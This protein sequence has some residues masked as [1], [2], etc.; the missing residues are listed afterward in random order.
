MIYLKILE[1]FTPGV[2]L[3]RVT[4]YKHDP[5]RR[6][7]RRVRGLNVMGPLHATPVRGVVQ[8][9]QPRQLDGL[10]DGQPPLHTTN[11]QNER[12]QGV[13]TEGKPL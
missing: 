4:V 3:G 8:Q 9:L 11:C 2:V 12:F 5:S 1:L 13:N 10:A 6:P 7:R